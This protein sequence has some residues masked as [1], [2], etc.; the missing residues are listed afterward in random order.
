[1]QHSASWQGLWNFDTGKSEDVKA[2]YLIRY[3]RS[4]TTHRSFFASF[5]ATWT[6][7]L[8][9]NQQVVLGGQT[10]ARA[11]DNRFQTGGRKFLL[12]LEQRQY[13]SVHLLNL[14]RL[15]FAAFID[16]GR[17]WEPGQANGLEDDLLA[18]VGIGIRLA[19][20]KA[21]VGRIIHIDF[22]FP[23]TNRN[24]PAVDSLQI[25]VNIKNT[26]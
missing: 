6:R 17:A 25:A 15:G 12:T 19:S 18:D 11:F 14:I 26:F 16:V 13:T 7:H 9:S 2:S 8:N 4:Q 21:S 22:A 24:H 3:F 1:M 23:L 10:G 20:S 5:D